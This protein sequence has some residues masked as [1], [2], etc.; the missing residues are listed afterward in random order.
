MNKKA[1]R[2]SPSC[3]LETIDNEFESQKKKIPNWLKKKH[4]HASGFELA[5]VEIRT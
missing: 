2:S 4:L 5:K 3:H 1:V